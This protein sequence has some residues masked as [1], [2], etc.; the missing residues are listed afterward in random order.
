MEQEEEEVEEVEEVLELRTQLV[1]EI[2]VASPVTATATGLEVEE[3]RG[4]VYVR[5]EVAEGD[6]VCTS[7]PVLLAVTA[8]IIFLQLC[9]LSTCVLCLYTSHTSHTSHTAKLA[10]ATVRPPSIN[11]IQTFNSLRT[12]FRD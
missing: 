2:F 10:S 5:G 7:W 12:T 11:S 9:L 4:P 1:K 3:R 6:L 8:G